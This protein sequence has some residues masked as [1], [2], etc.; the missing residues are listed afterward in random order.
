MITTPASSKGACRG[1]KQTYVLDAAG[2]FAGLE[3]AIKGE[4]VTSEE[5][6]REV[7]DLRSVTALNLAFAAGKVEVRR[8]SSKSVDHVKDV[9]RSLGEL[10]RLSNTDLKIL[11]ITYELLNE[12][13]EVIVVSDDRSVQNVSLELGATVMGIKRGVLRRP[14]KYVYVCPACGYVSQH[15]GVCPQCGSAELIRRR[16]GRR[17]R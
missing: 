11:A 15:P 8:P 9:A 16:A 1:R 14:R 5:V 10:G 12:G 3:N 6:I 2:F 7:K 4:V 17:R 13:R